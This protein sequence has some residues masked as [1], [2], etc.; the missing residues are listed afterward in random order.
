MM[1]TMMIM[2]IQVVVEY[3]FHGNLKDYVSRYRDYFIDELC[4]D[5]KVVLILILVILVIILILIII[6]VS[7]YS[8]SSSL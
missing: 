2:T 8:W 5:T 3:C 7:L 6:P 1:I 4:P